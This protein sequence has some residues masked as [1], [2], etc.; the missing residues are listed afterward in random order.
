METPDRHPADWRRTTRLSDR[1]AP[2]Q[3]SK[4]DEEYARRHC[5]TATNYAGQA[6]NQAGR[7]KP[8]PAATD[9]TVQIGT[10]LLGLRLPRRSS[11][12]GLLNLDPNALA[13][14]TLVLKHRSGHVL[15]LYEYAEITF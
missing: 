13:Y 8:Q 6:Q 15:P 14:E 4:A 11:C 7:S 10:Q 12:I 3:Q 1:Q 9:T 5:L 2:D